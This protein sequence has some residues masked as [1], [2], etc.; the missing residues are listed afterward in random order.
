MMAKL[1]VNPL[2]EVKA[3]SHWTPNDCA[4]PGEAQSVAIAD[5]AWFLSSQLDRR[6]VLKGAG[7]AVLGLVAASMSGAAA[8]AQ[9]SQA[10]STTA[11][12]AYVFNV[13]SRDVSLID[14]PTLS[15]RE[16]RPL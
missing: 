16:T 3:P 13:G 5:G 4:S 12:T 2:S 8:N 1:I 11:E 10:P 14:V 9:S 15:V 7:S 6:T